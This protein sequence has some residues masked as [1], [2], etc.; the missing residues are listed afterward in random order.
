MSHN[1]VR[2][3]WR[4]HYNGITIE[5]SMREITNITTK[6]LHINRSNKEKFGGENLHHPQ[7]MNIPVK[8]DRKY[9]VYPECYKTFLYAN[10]PF[11]NLLSRNTFQ[12]EAE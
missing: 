8:L 2:V 5:G 9:Y 1:F 11:I 4:Q 7:C 6:R 10:T 3:K 12:P